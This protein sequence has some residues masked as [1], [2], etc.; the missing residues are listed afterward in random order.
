L[1]YIF[2]YIHTRKTAW[3]DRMISGNDMPRLRK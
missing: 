1:E 3:T 2:I